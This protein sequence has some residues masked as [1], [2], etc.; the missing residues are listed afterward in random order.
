VKSFEVASFVAA[1]QQAATDGDPSGAVREVVAEAIADGRS[2]D[3]ALGNDVRGSL[4]TLFASPELTVQRI[5]WPAGIRSNPHDHRMWAVVGVYAGVEVNRLF[6]RSPHGLQERA[7]VDLEQ[8]H[9]LAL[10]DEAI[11]AVANPLRA[12]TAGLHV[13]GGDILDA[14]RRAWDPQGHEVP[15]DTDRVANRAMF[16]AIRDVAA[17]HGLAVTH[18]DVYRACDG[19]QSAC[20]QRGRY[21][22]PDEA[23]S[24]VEARWGLGTP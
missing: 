9:V 7:V 17:E 23:R 19:L 24:V 10:D 12:G 11:H 13:Y 4:D 8:G 22:E 1:C 14:G 15:F 20:E 5:V 6:E 3:A 18:D 2:I 16:L 21:L